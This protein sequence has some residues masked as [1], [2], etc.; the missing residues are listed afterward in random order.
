M[1]DEH[2]KNM[3][4]LTSRIVLRE[5]RQS[6]FDA[7]R[8]YESNPD[9]YRFEKATPDDMEIMTHL[10][11][12]LNW[13]LEKPRVH[14]CLA[15]TIQ[16]DDIVRGQITLSLNISEIK[17]W[18]IGWRVH[19][20]YWGRGYASEAATRVLAYAFEELHAHRVVAFCNVEN[21]AST[22]V[23]EKIGMI[24]DGRLRETRWWNS[25]WQDEYVYSILDRDWES[26]R[27]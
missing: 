7:L 12:V 4:L 20:Q 14:Y 21:K 22:R 19:Y 24:Q 6:D 27:K 25:A 11:Q 26:R 9:T 8:E 23:M 2:R 17:E 18:E 1:A 13:S 5:F 16:P 15:L 3:E 10:D